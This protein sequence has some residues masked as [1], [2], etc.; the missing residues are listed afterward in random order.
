MSRGPGRLQR[1]ALDLL[2]EMG[3]VTAEDLA[4][5]YAAEVRGRSTY[6]EIDL[7]SARRALRR[8]AEVGRTQVT[9]RPGSRPVRYGRKE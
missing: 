8:L 2:A 1:F 7:V 3:T 9:S 6:G 5:A 4:A